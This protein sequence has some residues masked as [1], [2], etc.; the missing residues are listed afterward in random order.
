[1]VPGQ[2]DTLDE[3]VNLPFGHTVHDICEL[4]AKVF[5]NLHRNYQ[6]HNWLSERAILAPKNVA[7]DDINAKLLAQLPGQASS[8]KYMSI[9]TVPDPDEVVNY[10]DEFL[11]SL[12]PA[13]LPPHSL[14]LKV[15]VPVMLL[16]NLDPLKLCNGMRLAIKK[17]MPRVLKATVMTGKAKG[18]DV[19]IPRIPFIPS[20]M[21]FEF[22][23]LQFP[24][25]PSFAMSINK[26]QGQSLKVV[27]LK[28]A[29][30]VFSH[31][32]LYVGCSRV[33]NSEQLYIHSP[34][35]MT[36]NIVYQEA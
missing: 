9:D 29:E 6:N 21:P 25:K 36:R 30:P 11:N 16:R 5:P 17:L 31:G 14:V 35:G 8:Y 1:M 22:R 34:G 26:A 32:Q 24:V 15:G 18:E 3:Q 13:G 4:V 12:A 20:D 28:L 10:P 2:P 33:G 7:V 27:G 19:F 23:C